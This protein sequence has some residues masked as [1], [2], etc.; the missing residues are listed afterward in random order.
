MHTKLMS[1]KRGSV[2]L[3]D[4]DEEQPAA[5]GCTC[6]R[7]Q[8]DAIVVCNQGARHTQALEGRKEGLSSR[9]ARNQ[10]HGSFKNYLEQRGLSR[11]ISW[12]RA[13]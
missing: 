3:S 5:R 9:F 2:E 4:C 13:H 11:V 7:V 1:L 10:M 12:R 6:D 8:Y